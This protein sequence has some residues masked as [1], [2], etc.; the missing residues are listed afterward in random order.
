MH[1]RSGLIPVALV[2]II[3]LIA[4]ILVGIAWW[5]SVEKNQQEAIVNTAQQIINQSYVNRTAVVSLHDGDVSVT[6]SKQQDCVLV[7]KTKSLPTC[8]TAPVGCPEDKSGENFVA[9]NQESYAAL[10][11]QIKDVNCNINSCPQYTPPY[12][13]GPYPDDIYG[14]QCVS[15]M[16]E[17]VQTS[18]VPLN[19]NN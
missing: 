14:A 7:D 2:I 10:G 6:C 4:A 17:K 8:C 11:R 9:V 18:I 1:H 3:G 16:C 12:C 15:G 13:P 19:T 5:Y